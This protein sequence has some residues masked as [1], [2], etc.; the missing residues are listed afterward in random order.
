M[1]FHTVK[2]GKQWNVE[3]ADTGEVKNANPYDNEADATAYSNALNAHSSDTKKGALKGMYDAVDVGMTADDYAVQESWDICQACAAMSSIAGLISSEKEEPDDISKL[4]AIMRS[5]NAFIS[6]EIDE[7]ES[8]GTQPEEAEVET[9]K[10]VPAKVRTTEPTLDLSYVKSLGIVIPEK[11]VSAKF[12]G[13]NEIKHYAFLWGSPDKTD[14]EA[15]YFT[16]STDFFDSSMGKSPRPL[17]WDHGQDSKFNKLVPSPVIGKTV[18]FGDDEWG[19]WAVSVLDTDQTYRKFVDR[20]IEEEVLGYS[21]DSAPQYI[22]R[23]PRGKGVWLKRWPWFGGA[24]TPAPCEPQM[25]QRSPE[26]LKSLGFVIPD[27][28]VEQERELLDLEA[29]RI[30]YSI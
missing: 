21:S 2:K 3:N 17:S 23:E 12:V 8:A 19:R 16:K 27:A 15:E 22:L 24:L 18:D 20:F 14:L 7:M 9:M 25:K 1:P 6:G 29:M 26:F 4:A 28:S 30:R 5:I 13:R 10:K 11:F